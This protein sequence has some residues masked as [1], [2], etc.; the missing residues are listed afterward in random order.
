MITVCITVYQAL[1]K[2]LELKFNGRFV[3]D[4]QS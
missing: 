3:S 1:R 4:T 2:P